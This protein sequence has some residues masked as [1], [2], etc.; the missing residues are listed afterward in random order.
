[1]E[2]NRIAIFI[3]AENLANW[4]KKGGAE[5]LLEELG[6]VGQ[7][8]VRK[9]YGIWTNLTAYQ[10]G[11]NRLG[12]E[13]I[14]SFHPVKG[15]NSTDIQMTV[16]IM[17]YVWR[18][19]NIN[20]FVLATGDSDF[21]PLFRRLR[22]MGKDV[23]G[24]GP[25]SALSESVK[26][27]CTRFIYT[28]TIILPANDTMEV[29]AK[30]EKIQAAFDD[31]ADLVEKVLHTTDNP[32]RCSLLKNRMQN[33][34]SAFDEKTIGFPS[35]TAFLQSLDGIKVYYDNDI[36]AWFVTMIDES[37]S[38][39]KQEKNSAS[40]SPNSPVTTKPIPL[41]DVYRQLL[42]KKGWTSIPKD[43]LWA[44]Y[45]RCA[46]LEALP[47]RDIVEKVLEYFEDDITSADI[48]KAIALFYKARLFTIG[49][50]ADEEDALYKLSLVA[51]D[52]LFL[53]I[54]KAMI[55]RLIRACEEKSIQ[56]DVNLAKKL[57]LSS[58][59]EKIIDRCIKEAQ[60]AEP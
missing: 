6:T 13:L 7:T 54:D 46:S 22:E 50:V 55:F 23:I 38:K 18:V 1:M 31:A 51:K 24:V 35:F 21:S 5:L 33:L 25:R 20:W 44:I 28:N 39:Q 49:K 37:K 10:A 53:E 9:A 30:D 59:N 41:D 3:D 47:K 29:A 34:D 26:S 45:D 19:E 40:K 17:E 43:D 57:L 11:L 4:L 2:Q 48:K 32:I 36:K 42:R 12:F 27:S 8:V 16:D 52:D 56:L 15:K 14:H 60:V 58:G